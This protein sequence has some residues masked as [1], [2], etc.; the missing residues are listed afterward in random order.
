M[1]GS[2]GIVKEIVY[3]NKE[4]P[5]NRNNLPAYVFVEFSECEIP[6]EE[7]LIDGMNSK[8]VPIPVVEDR[9]DKKCCSIRTIPLRVCIAITIH[10]S[11]GMTVGE[12]EIFEKV[13]VYLPEEGMRKHPGLELV[14]FSRVKRP[15]DLAVGNDST[16][17][18][19]T[20]ILKNGKGKIYDLRREFQ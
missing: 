13:V 9:C 14:A 4:G 1:N 18:T 15:E 12:G 8:C 20:Q 16:T 2:I 17:L 10:K 19:R 6:E 3:E 11:Q 5:A 7:N